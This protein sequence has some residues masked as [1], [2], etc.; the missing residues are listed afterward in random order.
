MSKEQKQFPKEIYLFK[1]EKLTMRNLI[2]RYILFTEQSFPKPELILGHGLC[3]DRD[4][5]LK[6]YHLAQ[7]LRR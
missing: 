7:W 5:P 2:Q 1:I 3:L 4:I 6:I